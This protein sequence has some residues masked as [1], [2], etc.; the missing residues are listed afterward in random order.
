MTVRI[1]YF[2]HTQKNIMALDF[3]V[4]L[5]PLVYSEN[6]IKKLGLSSKFKK[7]H[8]VLGIRKGLNTRFSEERQRY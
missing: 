6:F 3:D 8:Q 5:R 4:T 2:Y 7:L 1:T